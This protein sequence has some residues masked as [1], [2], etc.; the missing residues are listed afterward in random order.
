VW[1]GRGTE[2]ASWLEERSVRVSMKFPVARFGG[3]R[4]RCRERDMS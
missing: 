4:G 1:S 2:E 3:E